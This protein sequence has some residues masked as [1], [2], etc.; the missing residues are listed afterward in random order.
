MIVYRRKFIRIAEVWHGEEIDEA[1][2]VD[3]ARRFQRDAPTH[4][5]L[6]R[7]FHTILI[8]L[9]SD[10]EVLY[11][12]MR[13]GCR[14]KV[15]RAAERDALTY[16]CA[17]AADRPR[18]LAR[19]RSL[20]D[21]FAQRK[22]VPMLNHAWLS[23]MAATNNLYLSHVSDSNGRA[24]IWHTHYMSGGRATLLHSAPMTHADADGG[25]SLTGRANRYQHW[26]DILRFKRDGATLYDLGGWYSG[27]TDAQRLGINRFKEE[28]GGRIVRNYIDERA[29]T[30]K[31]RLFLR[32]RQSLL[33]DAI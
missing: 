29:L 32:A 18:L 4:G 15:H 33:G 10:E 12:A 23:L 6:C 5:A 13:K 11:N 24:L 30:I 22:R 25:R 26:Q 20:Y 28:F 19:F 16:E 1:T 27:N 7:E 2:R 3:V 14:Y 9:C 21:E 31:G 8:D 17:N